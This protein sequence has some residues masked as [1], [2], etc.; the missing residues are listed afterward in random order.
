MLHWS[1]PLIATP[2]ILAVLAMSNPVRQALVAIARILFRILNRFG[3]WASALLDLLLA[4]NDRD[5]KPPAWR[6]ILCVGLN[7]SAIAA[8]YVLRS[9]H[10]I[11]AALVA[12]SVLVALHI[13]LLTASILV[14]AEENRIM[15]HG[16]PKS[17]AMFR[18]HAAVRD[19]N[20]I[21]L[22][23]VLVLAS[24][25]ALLD[26]LAT[27][28]PGAILTRTPD[29]ISSFTSH[30]LCLYA[31]LPGAA[32]LVS[33][34]EFAGAIAFDGPLGAL[35]RGAIY[36]MGSTL[37]FGA[38]AAWI[39]Q[40]S[41]TAMILSRLDEADG[42]EA[43]FLQL[44]LSRAPQ[45]IKADLMTV[46]LDPQRQVAQT[47]AINVMRH[48][49]VWTFPQTFLHNLHRF[50]RKAKT[51]GLHQIREFLATDGADFDAEL[52]LAGTRKAFARY[53][54]LAT[55]TADKVGDG[56][57]SRLGAVIAQY[58]AIIQKRNIAFKTSSEQYGVMLEIAKAHKDDSVRRT[59]AGILMARSPKGFLKNFL[60]NMHE[61]D[62]GTID[63]EILGLLADFVRSRPQSLS[64]EDRDV[65][66]RR[67]S[68]SIRHAGLDPEVTS[69]LR[70]LQEALNA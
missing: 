16:E 2:A 21:L 23:I 12:T 1:I 43:H 66:A 37:L 34:T 29:T 51:N 45:H 25:A 9:S 46:A 70:G 54:E 27:L 67:L 58:M 10:G 11:H 52:I 30:L 41:A 69:A 17:G 8:I 60:V 63:K 5:G 13:M 59:M 68:W 62:I 31:A 53:G 65:V 40:R 50:E 3:A 20:V 19:F 57:L 44:L 49:Q 28:L 35:V 61:R 39:Y 55:S 7:A 64:E 6:L 42:N 14:I 26:M 32:A 15:H 24:S 18:P 48:L 4:P 33:M 38:A 36:V 56:V 47:R 22:E